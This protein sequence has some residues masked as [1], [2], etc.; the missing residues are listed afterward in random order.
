MIHSETHISEIQ[1]LVDYNFYASW[2]K[3]GSSNPYMIAYSC[4]SASP[5]YPGGDFN[6]IPNSTDSLAGHYWNDISLM[7]ALGEQQ[8]QFL[9]LSEK[10]QLVNQIGLESNVEE[11]VVSPTYSTLNSANEISLYINEADKVL[12]SASDDQEYKFKITFDKPLA[13]EE[14]TSI[15]EQYNLNSSIF[16]ARAYNDNGDRVTIALNGL[17]E[18]VLKQIVENQNL[19]LSGFIEIE[20]Q[21]VGNVLK[22]AKDSEVNIFS[23]EIAKDEIQP[24]GLYWKL[25]NSRM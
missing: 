21:T 12:L 16:Y 14:V 7:S 24:N 6:T 23:V 18:D 1:D 5:L 22:K 20:G 25:E 3:S 15:N 9:S 4:M 8:P 13:L 11:P 17:N 19:E 10:M 2:S